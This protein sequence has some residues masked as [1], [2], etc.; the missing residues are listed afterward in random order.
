MCATV[1][2]REA[3][4]RAF[5]L[6]KAFNYGRLF[7]PSAPGWSERATEKGKLIAESGEKFIA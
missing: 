6:Q 7:F 4:Q 5:L 2:R 3:A 1:E